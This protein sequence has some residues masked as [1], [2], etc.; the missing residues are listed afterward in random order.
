VRSIPAVHGDQSVS[1][2]LEWKGLKFAFSSDT[3]PNKWWVQYT[4]GCGRIGAR[5]VLAAGG[6][7]SECANP[8]QQCNFEGR[9]QHQ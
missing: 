3:V 1:F 8:I 5:G 6:D 9:P 7:D 2:I 4:K